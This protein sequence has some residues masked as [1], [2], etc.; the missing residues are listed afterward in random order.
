MPSMFYS[1]VRV[2]FVLQSTLQYT[3]VAKLDEALGE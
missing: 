3:N 2:I 1:L